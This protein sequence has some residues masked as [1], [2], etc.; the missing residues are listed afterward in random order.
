VTSSNPLPRAEATRIIAFR[1]RCPLTTGGGASHI[2]QSLAAASIERAASPAR[3][4]RIQNIGRGLKSSGA[5]EPP[6]PRVRDATKILQGRTNDSKA[7]QAAGE[8]LTYPLHRNVLRRYRDAVSEQWHLEQQEEAM[9]KSLVMIA[10]AFVIMLAGSLLS[11]SAE[12]GASASAPAKYSGAS[13][14]GYQAWTGW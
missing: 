11:N 6:Q 9:Y 5:S 3:R 4:R 10:A 2:H 13:S 8:Q 1:S 12:A 14:A 7:E